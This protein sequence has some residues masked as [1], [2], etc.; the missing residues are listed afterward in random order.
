M[1]T[2]EQTKIG[3]QELPW[4]ESSAPSNIALIKYMGKVDSRSG[5]H[6]ATQS[7][8]TNAATVT[9][10]SRNRPTNSSLS[11]TLQH[12]RTFVRVRP[13]Q[14][15]DAEADVWQPFVR[16]DLLVM[17]LTEFGLAKYLNFFAEL[18]K[19]FKLKGFFEIESGNNFP[20]DAGLASSAS[21]F[22]ALTMVAHEVYKKN[23]GQSVYTAKE[24]A[25]ISQKGSGSSC[26]SF[27]KTWSSC[28]AG[29]LLQKRRRLLC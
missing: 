16:S 26:R 17:E 7:A 1:T 5:S 2:K 13:L 11:W 3:K 29:L 21:S 10:Y 25:K 6:T 22:A 8:L 18:K 28:N 20:A 9:E 27:F 12:L 19:E 23:G 24:L 15:E 4:V 14:S